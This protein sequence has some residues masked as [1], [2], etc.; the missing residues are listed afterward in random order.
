M[1]QLQST[2]K[3]LTMAKPVVYIYIYIKQIINIT[4]IN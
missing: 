4:S 2:I 3:A 1:N